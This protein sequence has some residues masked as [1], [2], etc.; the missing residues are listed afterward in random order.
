MFSFLYSLLVKNSYLKLFLGYLLP[1]K[2]VGYIIKKINSN[3]NKNIRIVFENHKVIISSKDSYG[4][5]FVPVVYWDGRPNF[6]DMIGPYLISKITGKPVLNILDSTMPG[7]MAVGSIL[8]LINRKGMIVWGTG[9]MKEPTD[10]VIRK[11]KSYEPE[12]LTVR[13]EETAKCLEKAGIKVANMDALGDPGLI[14]PFFYTP[15]LKKNVKQVAICPHYIHK[16]KFMSVF[17]EQTGVEFIDVQNDLESVVDGISASGVC[18][19][20]SLH[21]LIISQAYGVPWVWLEVVDDN[22][23]GRDF[24]FNDFFST[25]DSSQVSHVKINL[26]YLAELDLHE[27]AAKAS[28][29]VKKYKED[30]ILDSLKKNL[31]RLA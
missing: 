19:S 28:L 18:I 12:V 1:R 16:L 5:G 25:L 24:K 21:G 26:Q 27:I 6:G 8:Q 17:S 11:L 3:K 10:Q 23:A 14:M 9:L 2:V 22:L 7:F 20:T 4:E 13:G 15:K 29:P 30:L 31:I